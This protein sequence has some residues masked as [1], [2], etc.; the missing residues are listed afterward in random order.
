MKI[1]SG[2]T[3][4]F[5]DVLVIREETILAAKVYRKLTHIGRYLNFSSNH[6][7]HV[8][9]HHKRSS[10]I[11]LDLCSEIINLRRDF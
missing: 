8:K 2:S 10:T 9:S 6:P 5:L 1:Q 11:C 7:P 4:P 3:I